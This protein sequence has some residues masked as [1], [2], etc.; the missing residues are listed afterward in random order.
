MLLFYKTFF[1][2]VATFNEGVIAHL[3]YEHLCSLDLA[4]VWLINQICSTFVPAFGSHE[5][6]ND[7]F[8][9]HARNG[10]K[11]LKFN[12]LEID[13]FLVSRQNRV[14]SLSHHNTYF[15]WGQLTWKH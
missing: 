12:D 1:L 7:S 6:V 8:L 4:K 9:Y 3:L 5:N 15:F 13:L 2:A 10:T 11:F 14:E